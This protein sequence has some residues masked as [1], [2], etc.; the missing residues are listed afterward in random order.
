V[1]RTNKP[2]FKNQWNQCL[3]LLNPRNPWFQIEKVGVIGEQN[4]VEVAHFGAKMAR[5]GALLAAFAITKSPKNRVFTLKTHKVSS[6]VPSVGRC[7]RGLL[8]ILL[9]CQ[10]DPVNP[11]KKKQC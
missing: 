7:P 1:D 4:G 11:V 8:L 5:F 9:S 2:N 6:F 10:K 3:K